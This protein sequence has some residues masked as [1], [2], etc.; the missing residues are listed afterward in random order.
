MYTI[1]FCPFCNRVKKLLRDKGVDFKEINI[2]QTPSAKEE[3]TK[4]IPG[5][6]TVP[7]V[8]ADGQHVGDCGEIFDLEKQNL[9]NQALGLA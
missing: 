1:T 7:Q 4:R 2:E 9:L 5:R 3:L 8:F 6:H